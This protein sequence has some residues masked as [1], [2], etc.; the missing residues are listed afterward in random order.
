MCI[1]ESVLMAYASAYQGDGINLHAKSELSLIF[2]RTLFLFSPDGFRT[3][4]ASMNTTNASSHSA[5]TR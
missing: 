5:R 3:D 4:V 2:C 1:H